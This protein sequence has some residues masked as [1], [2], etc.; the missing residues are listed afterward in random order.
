M[1]EPESTPSAT[2]PDAPTT[3]RLD[4]WKDIASYLKRDIS[5][6]QRWERRESMP[7]Y[8]HQHDHRGSVYA[9]R[10]EL[11]RWIA[12]RS[13]AVGSAGSVELSDAAAAQPTRSGPQHRSWRP[14]AAAAVVLALGFGVSRVLRPAQGPPGI[15]SIVVLPLQNLSGDDSQEYFADGMTEAV[16]GSLTSIRGLRVISRTSAMQFKGTH[17]SVPE[18]ARKLSV[19]AIVEGSVIRAA[20]RVRVHVQ[21]IRGQTDE[22]VWS[23]TYD[24]ELRDVLTLET[25]IAFAIARQVQITVT[26]EDDGRTVARAVAA[27]VYDN[28]LRGRF[29]LNR[30]TR[31][32]ATESIGYFEAALA[33][34]PS[35]APAYAGIASAYTDLGLV[36][37]GGGPPREAR[38]KAIAAARNALALDPNLIEAHVRLGDALQKDWQWKEAEAEFQRAVQL[39]PNSAVANAMFAR[40]LIC[41]GRF[42]EAIAA[43][44]KARSLDPLALRAEHLGWVLFMSRRYKEAIRAIEDVLATRPDDA[45]A[46]WELGFARLL[47]GQPRPAIEA[48]ERAADITNRGP[49]VL[50]VI[51]HAYAAAGRSF[52]ASRTLDELHHRQASEYVPAAALVNA[53]VGLRDPDQTLFWLE[54]SITE[55]STIVQYLAVHPAFD[56][57][58]SDPRFAGLARRVGLAE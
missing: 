15:R 26:A 9:I 33:A 11:D 29:A 46:L 25:Q 49:A 17:Q 51:V 24:R 3:E 23:A 53:Y 52:D 28:Y 41:R 32:G 56:F 50:G 2:P 21:M 42:D 54:R 34:D 18:I 8:R 58:R 22:H 13:I 1:T 37:F 36:L 10:S 19:D 5:T 12:S 45:T 43:A 20:D 44:E 40:Y 39:A 31:A 47:D 48:L 30:N 7:V 55:G 6:V 38:P 35:F 14:V 16:I 57:I 27:D 4:S